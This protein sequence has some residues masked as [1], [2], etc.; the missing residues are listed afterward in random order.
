M[1]LSKSILRWTLVGGVALGVV[2]FLVGPSR[3]GAAI[4]QVRTS[5][6]EATE[7][8]VDDPVALRRQLAELAEEYPAR[9]A[10]VQGEL[11]AVESQIRQIQHSRD[12]AE[13][14]VA[15]TG[16]DLQKLRALAE[17]AADGRRTVSLRTGRA[18]VASE[19]AL[20]EAQRIRTIREAY[21]DRAASDGQQLAMLETQ[22]DRLQQILDKLQHEQIRFQSR[23]WQ[24]DGQIDAIARNDRLIELTKQQQEILAEYDRFGRVGNLDQLE[25][26]IAQIRAEQDARLESLA[27]GGGHDYEFAAEENLANER[28]GLIDPFADLDETD[29][30]TAIDDPMEGSLSPSRREPVVRR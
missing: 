8:L 19:Q 21:R 25:S 17:T 23:M 26:R 15:M 11:A 16:D 30:S 13:R 12:V 6:I 24:L 14:V 18:S 20:G 7:D 1:S 5:L 4:D 2:T 27:S 3:V 29:G 28:S 10:E 22:R 9:V